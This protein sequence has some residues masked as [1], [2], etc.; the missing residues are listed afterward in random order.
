MVQEDHILVGQR[1]PRHIAQ[2]I[3]IVRPMFED[4]PGCVKHALIIAGE[5]SGPNI[6]DVEI[7]APASDT[8]RRS[9]RQLLRSR[10]ILG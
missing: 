6:I 2:D 8:F 10:I 5:V 3:K 4:V 1:T 7:R 9:A